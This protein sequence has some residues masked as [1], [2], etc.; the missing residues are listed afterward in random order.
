MEFLRR[1]FSGDSSV[2]CMRVM[3]M[4][5]LLL[6]AGVA[7]LQIFN[8]CKLSDS[9]TIVGIFVGSAFGG[10][11]AQKFAEYKGKHVK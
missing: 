6:G 5:S 9:A 2:S 1:M 4:L 7:Y 11:V 3:S 10:K 8:A